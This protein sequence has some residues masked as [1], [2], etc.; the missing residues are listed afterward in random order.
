[1][2]IFIYIAY[3]TAIGFFILEGSFQG[4]ADFD[5]FGDTYY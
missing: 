1:M 3:F 5:S 4:F 2:C